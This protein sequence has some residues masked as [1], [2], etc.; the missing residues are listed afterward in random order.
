VRCLIQMRM[1]ALLFWTDVVMLPASGKV[2]LTYP[3]RE[4]WRDIPAEEGE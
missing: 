1:Q 2:T 3:S 4:E